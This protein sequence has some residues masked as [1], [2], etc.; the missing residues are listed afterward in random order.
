MEIIKKEVN[1]NISVRIPISVYEEALRI[2]NEQGCRPADVWRSALISFFDPFV[3]K[4]DTEM[5][6]DVDRHNGVAS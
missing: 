4:S 6:I 1:K 5:S 3:N 2:A